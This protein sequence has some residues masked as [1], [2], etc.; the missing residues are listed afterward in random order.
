MLGALSGFQV[1]MENCK[2]G[3]DSIALVFCY[4]SNFTDFTV[5]IFPV[6]K[7]TGRDVA[8]CPL[9]FIL[10]KFTASQTGQKQE[11]PGWRE[12]ERVDC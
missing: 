3:V 10:Y 6:A 11:K 9:E 8:F 1:V 12:G 2:I 5:D 4:F 7:P